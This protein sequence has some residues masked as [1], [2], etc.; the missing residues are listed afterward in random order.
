MLPANLWLA[1]SGPITRSFFPISFVVFHWNGSSEKVKPVASHSFNGKRVPSSRR[2]ATLRRSG[3]ASTESLA[4]AP[5][6]LRGIR[7]FSKLRFRAVPLFRTEGEQSPGLEIVEGVKHFRSFTFPAKRSMPSHNGV[8]R[9]TSDTDQSGPQGRF[10]FTDRWPSL[11]HTRR[12]HR[13]LLL[14][15]A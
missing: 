8:P 3:V 7:S 1:V 12:R 6:V 13:M 9:G 11:C 14:F 5:L 15:I 2:S 4:R 10:I